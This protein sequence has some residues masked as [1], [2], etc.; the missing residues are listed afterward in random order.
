MKLLDQLVARYNG[1]IE[2]GKTAHNE[3]SYLETKI[4]GKAELYKEVIELLH[5]NSKQFTYDYLYKL[6]ED[7]VDRLQTEELE[8]DILEY[9]GKKEAC[10]EIMV[11]LMKDIKECEVITAEEVYNDLLAIYYHELKKLNGHILEEE[12]SE[13]YFIM[14]GK[15]I[16]LNRALKRIKKLMSK[17]C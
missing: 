9:T 5:H 2:E 8:E 17:E 14:Q 13:E 1:L 15:V 12:E 7:F 11:M 16:G 4:Y 10:E 3:H 6:H